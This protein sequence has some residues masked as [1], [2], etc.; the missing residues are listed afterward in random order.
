MGK[1]FTRMPIA[2]APKLACQWVEKSTTV[3]V[4]GTARQDAKKYEADKEPFNYL[5]CLEKRMKKA[6]AFCYKRVTCSDPDEPLQK[7]INR[8][9]ALARSRG[10]RHEFHVKQVNAID[11]FLSYQ[12]FGT[13]N[14]EYLLMIGI[15]N[16][17]GSEFHTVDNDFCLFTK[18]KETI[19]VFI[20]HFQIAWDK[21]CLAVDPIVSKDVTS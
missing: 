20:K 6:K 12:I 13:D 15:D 2:E 1:E 11:F 10:N 19:A 4:V 5:R 16:C 21:W 8:C 7:H 17:V 14:E 9:T 3:L 18:D